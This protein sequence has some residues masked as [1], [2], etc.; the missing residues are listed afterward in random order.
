MKEKRGIVVEGGERGAGGTHC[1]LEG[2]WKGRV[3]MYV[4]ISWL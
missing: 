1:C 4:L 3:K 2:A